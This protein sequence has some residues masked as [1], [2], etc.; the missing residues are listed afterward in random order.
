MNGSQDDSHNHMNQRQR[1][2]NDTENQIDNSDHDMDN[3]DYDM[4]HA[5]N[6]ESDTQYDKALRIMMSL[7]EEGANTSI[8]N[9]YDD[10][11]VIKFMMSTMNERWKKYYMNWSKEKDTQ[12]ELMARVMGMNKYDALEI[13]SLID[14]MKCI[15]E[16]DEVKMD[17][18][19]KEQNVS[20]QIH[21]KVQQM[22]GLLHAKMEFKSG[23]MSRQFAK[24][25]KELQDRDN[26]GKDKNKNKKGRGRRRRPPRSNKNKNKNKND[27]EEVSEEEEETIITSDEDN[28]DNDE[29]HEQDLEEI[30]DFTGDD[31]TQKRRGNIKNQNQ[32]D[33]NMKQRI[34]QK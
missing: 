25:E 21:D 22:D 28:D 26:K 24:I 20:E 32:N 12:N 10:L 19:L 23:F 1:V 5:M 34:E 6:T 11:F 9:L 3:N 16:R 29:E 2:M 15:D 30:E 14:V 7:D 4:N 33:V 18:I 31:D 17:Q 27:E 13:D 8:Q